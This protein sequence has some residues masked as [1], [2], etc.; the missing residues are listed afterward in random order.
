[1]WVLHEVGSTSTADSTSLVPATG[2]IFSPF[3]MAE[4]PTP[5]VFSAPTAS[6]S[7]ASCDDGIAE[8]GLTLPDELLR[9]SLPSAGGQGSPLIALKS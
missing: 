5:L 3:F 9:F 4:D 8:L 1:M 7:G 6:C 2:G